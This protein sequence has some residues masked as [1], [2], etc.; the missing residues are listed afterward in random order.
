[1]PLLKN[2]KPGRRIRWPYCGRAATVVGHGQMGT[3]VR[4]R[5]GRKVRFQ[6]KSGDVVTGTREFTAKAKTYVVASESTV[7]VLK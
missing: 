2:V 3:V 5:D 6:T 1:M 7:E 4:Y